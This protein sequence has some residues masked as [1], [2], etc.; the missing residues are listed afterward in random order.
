MLLLYCPKVVKVPIYWCLALIS[1]I[2]NWGRSQASFFYH[3]QRQISFIPFFFF[4]FLYISIVFLPSPPPHIYCF[5]SS[6]TYTLWT[7]HRPSIAPHFIHELK[8]KHYDVIG[9]NVFLRRLMR[10]SRKNGLFYPYHTL[11]DRHL[12][13]ESWFLQ[14]RYGV[15]S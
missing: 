5:S 3:H 4:L 1:C 14:S 15:D 6:S 8:T 2:F 12:R 10:F 9:V 7:P 11:K 13:E